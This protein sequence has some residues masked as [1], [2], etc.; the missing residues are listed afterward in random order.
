MKN[1]AM[2]V[3]GRLR[4]LR[5]SYSAYERLKIVN[6]VRVDEADGG[7]RRLVPGRSLAR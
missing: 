4:L 2:D 3:L 6:A 7:A 5:H 1:A